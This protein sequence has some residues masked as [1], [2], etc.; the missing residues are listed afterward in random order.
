MGRA[1]GTDH[2][3]DFLHRRTLPDHEPSPLDT[4]LAIPQP[5]RLAVGNDTVRAPVLSDVELR[6]TTC[7]G[8]SRNGLSRSMDAYHYFCLFVIREPVVEPVNQV[9]PSKE[10]ATAYLRVRQSWQTSI[11]CVKPGCASPTVSRSTA[12]IGPVLYSL[13]RISQSAIATTNREFISPGEFGSTNKRLCSQNRAAVST[14][15][16]RGNSVGRKS[17]CF[18]SCKNPSGITHSGVSSGSE[19]WLGRSLSYMRLKRF[20]AEEY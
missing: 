6:C 14:E 15:V 13:P 20:C 19:I 12:T 1:G 7:R 17:H 8:L 3:L 5:P 16:G 2:H 18:Q 11:S 9:L 4:G 10:L